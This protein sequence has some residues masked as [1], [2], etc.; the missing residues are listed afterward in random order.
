MDL[1]PEIL[2]TQNKPLPLTGVTP[3]R[4]MGNKLWN[5]T[6]AN[7]YSQNGDKCWCCG[8]HKSNAWMRQWLE[9]HEVYAIDYSTGEVTIAEFTALC[10]A[11]HNFIHI[12]QLVGTNLRRTYEKDTIKTIVRHGWRVLREAGLTLK[13][14]MTDWRHIAWTDWYL[15]WQ[16]KRYYSDFYSEEEWKGQLK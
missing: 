12:D 10:W 11:C 6:R 14:T 7:A 8:I 13:R 15:L 9:C 16:G 5:K 4:V 1:R 3:R 2:L